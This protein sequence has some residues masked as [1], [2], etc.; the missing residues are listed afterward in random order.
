MNKKKHIQQLVV[1]S[2]NGDDLDAKTVELIADHMNR[3]TMKQYISLLK[4][5]EKKK[6]VIITSPRSLSDADK[7]N[8]KKLFPKKK[9][10][11]I[12]DPEMINGIQVTDNNQ[13]YDLNLNQT[14]HDIIDHINKYD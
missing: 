1:E 5:N 11:Y 12:L 2:Y 14:F 8:L 13:A 3:Q 10:M 6:Q 7:N 9:I 4:Q